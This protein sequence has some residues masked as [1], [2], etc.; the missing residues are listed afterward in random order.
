M[1]LFA[2]FGTSEIFEDHLGF[3]SRNPRTWRRELDAVV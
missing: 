1:A 3:L 2:G